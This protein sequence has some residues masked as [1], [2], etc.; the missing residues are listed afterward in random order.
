ME[1]ASIQQFQ[2]NLAAELSQDPKSAL[3]TC[4][5]FELE[6]CGNVEPSI[7]LPFYRIQLMSYLPHDLVNARWLWERVPEVV[8]A[9]P[10]MQRIWEVVKMLWN[11]KLPEAYQL[12][13]ASWASTTVQ[14]LVTL[15][16]EELRSRKI[17]LI[18]D[19]HSSIAIANCSQLLGLNRDETIARCTAEGWVVAGEFVQPT[20]KA[21]EPPTSVDI[22]RLQALTNYV[23]ALD[24]HT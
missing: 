5:D 17:Q 8:K 15:L 6:H 7:S 14:P 2:E 18:A 9:D 11:Q 4:E 1:P 12:L 23:C 20:K 16:I 3:K 22:E 10:E 13:G 19:S 21:I 24:V